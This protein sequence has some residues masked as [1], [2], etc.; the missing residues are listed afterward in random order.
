MGFDQEA[1][2]RTLDEFHEKI[3]LVFEGNASEK[4]AE[5]IEKIIGEEE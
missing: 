5:K 3:G 1:Y 2:D 4:L